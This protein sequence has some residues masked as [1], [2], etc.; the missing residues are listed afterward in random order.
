MY[1]AR[2][3]DQTTPFEAVILDDF[4]PR[5]GDRVSLASIVRDAGITSGNPFADGYLRLVQA[6]ANVILQFDADR[7]GLDRER[8]VVFRDAY[9]H[10]FTGDTFFI[11]GDL[12]RP[13]ETSGLAL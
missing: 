1:L 7:D 12:V 3:R 2:D 5:A 8:L 11:A 6:G 13:A 10:E 9:K 4:D